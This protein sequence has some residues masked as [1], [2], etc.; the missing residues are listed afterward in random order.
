MITRTDA[1]RLTVALGKLHLAIRATRT[2]RT[3]P[4]YYQ[5]R[6]ERDRQ[7]QEYLSEMTRVIESGDL[8]KILETHRR[9]KNRI[10][11]IDIMM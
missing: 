1:A 7:R 2:S 8:E 11:E 6:Q 3:L 4:A 9:L 5:Q 10:P